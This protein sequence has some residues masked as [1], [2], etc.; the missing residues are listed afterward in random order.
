MKNIFYNLIKLNIFSHVINNLFTHNIFLI[1]LL[2]FGNFNN[3][4]YSSETS[5]ETK[6][7]Q[8]TKEISEEKESPEE[9]AKKAGQKALKEEAEKIAKIKNEAAENA[10]SSL[11]KKTELSST[12][13][14]TLKNTSAE[15]SKIFDKAIEE[16]SEKKIMESL[17][18]EY[19]NI[20]QKP[21]INTLLQK[22]GVV[23]LKN[24]LKPLKNAANA[25]IDRNF[26]KKI[27][28]KIIDKIARK[29]DETVQNKIQEGINQL[30]KKAFSATTKKD[31]TEVLEKGY[32]E[33][34]KL[35]GL[36][37]DSKIGLAT[38][39]LAVNQ[40]LKK[41][42]SR[43]VIM[44][45][46][47]QIIKTNEKLLEQLKKLPISLTKEVQ[48]ELQKGVN[49]LI[50]RS[51]SKTPKEL[52]AF[53]EAG[54]KDLIEKAGLKSSEKIVT[55]LVKSEV[56]A[57]TKAIQKKVEESI[58]KAGLKKV[59][60]RGA[61]KD[62]ALCLF[63]YMGQSYTETLFSQEE[64]TERKEQFDKAKKLETDLEK[65]KQKIDEIAAQKTKDLLDKFSKALNIS[66][67]LPA[68]DANFKFKYF[69]TFQNLLADPGMYL[70]QP[71]GEKSDLIKIDKNFQNSPLL[72]PQGAVW[73]NP[74]ALNPD[75]SYITGN[76]AYD[77][78]YNGFIQKGVPSGRYLWAGI[79][80]QLGRQ[81]TAE[82]SAEL[83]S[84]FTEAYTKNDVYNIKL[85]FTIISHNYPFLV[86]LIFNKARWLSGSWERLKTYRFAGIYGEDEKNINFY[87][88]QTSNLVDPDPRKLSSPIKNILSKQITPT[89]NFSEPNLYNQTFILELRVEVDKVEI[90]LTKKVVDSEQSVSIIKPTIIPFQASKDQDKNL[91]KKENELIFFY[92]GIGFVSTGAQAIF[93]LKEGPEISQEKS[94]LIYS[95]DAV[96]NFKKEIYEKI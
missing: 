95:E 16:N 60:T 86:G 82:D 57:S 67:D 22:Y 93:I 3:K 79:K 49:D 25:L 87:V 45:T 64:D 88:A 26:N 65:T 80:K 36:P 77:P 31:L 75:I 32:P 50:K 34:V 30:I 7:E 28:L 90:K 83:N 56:Q 59:A 12:E 10:I 40:A 81:C 6:K 23:D 96:T 19:L 89:Y 69:A 24:G 42:V 54:T 61:V 37:E 53:I 74:F 48:D 51:V 94:Q 47:E 18:T 63:A 4:I 33:I 14:L 62:I 91:K 29:L 41:D 92:H 13:K 38:L 52:E 27:G 39:K 66:F 5:L 15:L 72:T 43:Q 35:A 76:W 1:I 68:Q 70:V 58:I 2:I 20:L 9:I 55:S 21:E 8:P 73:Y 46:E 84:I 11:I 78:D 85:E 17:E 44:A 71:V